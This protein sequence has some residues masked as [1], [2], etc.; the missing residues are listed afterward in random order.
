MK[1]R[2]CIALAWP[3]RSKK[4]TSEQ[5]KKEKTRKKSRMEDEEEELMG[6]KHK[7]KRSMS[8]L[9]HPPLLIQGPRVQRRML[10]QRQPL[11]R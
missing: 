2:V 1:T 4:I 9:V 11:K 10:K 8:R 5:Q 7:T 6:R 3:R